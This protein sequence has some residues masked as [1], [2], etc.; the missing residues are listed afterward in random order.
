[1]V[2]LYVEP[3]PGILLQP[4]VLLSLVPF[5]AV[6]LGVLIGWRFQQR[7]R[8]DGAGGDGPAP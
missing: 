3:G 4:V 5:A 7:R 6:A 1:M 8:R 2:L